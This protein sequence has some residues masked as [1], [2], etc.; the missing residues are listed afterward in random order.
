MPSRTAI[1]DRLVVRAAFGTARIYFLNAEADR[2]PAYLP[3][4]IINGYF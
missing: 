2:P 1:L 3:A 4:L